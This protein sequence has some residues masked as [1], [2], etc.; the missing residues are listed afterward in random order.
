MTINYDPRLREYHFGEWEGRAWA[1]IPRVQ[2][3]PWLA[4]LWGAAPPGGETFA[5]VHAR[6]AEALDDISD[7]TL[8]VAHAGVI[9][10]ARMILTGAD[11]QTVFAEKVPHCQPLTFGARAA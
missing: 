8:V 6:V 7:G 4:D 11:F 3:E 10:A 9:R 2:S 5:T 1:D